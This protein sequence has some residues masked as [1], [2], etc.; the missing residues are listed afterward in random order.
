LNKFIKKAIKHP[1]SL[2]RW[3]KKHGFIDSKGRIKLNQAEK[4]AK[5]HH[6]SHREKEI[7]LAR[8]LRRLRA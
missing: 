1:G 5:R 6:L 3:A 7:N 2:R 4:Y 8:T